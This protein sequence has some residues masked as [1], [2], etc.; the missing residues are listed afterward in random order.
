MPYIQDIAGGH[1]CEYEHWS[2]I[3]IKYFWNREIKHGA[4]LTYIHFTW[5]AAHNTSINN[6]LYWTN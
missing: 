1:Q 4:M 6:N 2:D 3:F 5:V